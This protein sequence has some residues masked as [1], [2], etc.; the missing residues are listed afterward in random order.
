V[1]QTSGNTWRSARSA[2]RLAVIW[3][4][5]AATPLRAW[6][7]PAASWGLVFGSI[8]KTGYPEELY[9]EPSRSH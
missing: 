1:R 8:S 7:R 4:A 6:R 2:D 9:S 3:G 5:A